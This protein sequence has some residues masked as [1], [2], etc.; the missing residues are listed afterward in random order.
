MKVAALTAT[1]MV[2]V[3]YAA[4]MQGRADRATRALHVLPSTARAVLWV[5]SRTLDRSAAARALLEAFVPEEQL[6]EI[7]VSCGIDPIA[8]LAE[9]TLWV[10]GSDRE[11]FQ[12]FGLVLTGAGVD[13]ARIAD[14]HEQLVDARGGSVARIDAPTGPLLASDD[15]RSAIA[16]VDDRTVI[17]GAVQT[18]TE[19]MAV[20][21]GLLPSLSE[22][23][24]VA[25]MWPR[26]R[27]R[28]AIAAAL[29]LPSHWQAALQEITT[30]EVVSS[31]LHGIDAIGLAARPAER[32]VA[33]VHLHAATAELAAESAALIRANAANPPDGVEPPW[34]ELLRSAKVDLDGHYIVVHV[35]LSS[36]S[37]HH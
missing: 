16:L 4:L 35:D 6:S 10:R 23:P 9:A 13:A 7:E 34:D 25:G 32:P 22:R 37:A 21:R 1:A 27:A 19:A 20:R 29:E 31:A 14:C 33:E 30:F 17:T 24:T 36:L 15:L 28:S 3:I 11:P 26:V 8:D 2:V 12:S 5:D 18:V